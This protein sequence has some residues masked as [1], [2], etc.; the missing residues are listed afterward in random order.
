MV[1]GSKQNPSYTMEATTTSGQTVLQGLLA[2]KLFEGL[3]QLTNA[4]MESARKHLAE[5]ETP[6]EKD[7][8]KLV[9]KLTEDELWIYA[10]LCR[11]VKL[12]GDVAQKA[13]GLLMSG[14]KIDVDEQLSMVR[15][16]RRLKNQ[17]DLIKSI[18]W[19]NFKARFQ[20]TLS[21]DDNLCTV[22]IDTELNVRAMTHEEEHGSSPDELHVMVLGGRRGDSLD[23]LAE[24]LAGLHG[25]R[26]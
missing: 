2:S 16:M 18:F 17:G 25:V 7:K 6:E 10:L 19:Y 21:E 23:G 20:Q 4:D 12:A 15:E 11:Q 26:G 1:C 13:I 5:L 3:D 22:R 9:G 24:M 8:G 14:P